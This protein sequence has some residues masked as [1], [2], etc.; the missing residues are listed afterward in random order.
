MNFK[1]GSTTEA[2]RGQFRGRQ[3]VWWSPRRLVTMIRHPHLERIGTNQS[4]FFAVWTGETERRGRDTSLRHTLALLMLSFL[5][6]APSVA[7]AQS[8]KKIRD[9]PATASAEKPKP[10]E[11][12][13][14]PEQRQHN[15]DSFDYVWTTIRDKYFDPSLGGLDWE[16]VKDELRPKVEK[17]ESMSQ[18][19]AVLLDVTSRLKVSHFAIIP[20]QAYGDLRQ[21]EKPRGGVTGIDV[22]VIDSRVLVTSVRKG[23]PAE[24]AGVKTGWEIVRIDEDDLTTKLKSLTDK[25]EQHPH[26]RTIL[27]GAVQSR[28]GGRIGE[29]RPLVFRDGDDREVKLELPFIEPKGR[30]TRFGHIPEFRVWIDVTSVDRNI[31]Y[32]GFNAF[33]DPIHVMTRFN[34]AMESFHDSEGIIIDVR[35]NGG[36]MGGMAMGMIGWLVDKG[37]PQLGTVIFRDNQLKM[38]VNPR[39]APFRGPV[40]VLIDEMSGSAAE[41]FASGVKD[42]GRAHLIGTRTAG[43]VLGSAIEKLPNGDGFQYAAVNYISKKTGKPLEGIGVTPDT[44]APH[45]REALL[46][47]RDLAMEAAI[48]WIRDQSRQ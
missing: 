31:G 8:S 47:G 33:I 11:R 30:K 39:P 44:P 48:K 20:S 5:L 32:I 28:L 29:T 1:A 41:F 36:G 43:A 34:E 26:R 10:A 21:A 38:L 17:A 22:R 4:G 12:A 35:G 7:S 2:S 14:T 23:S 25:L 19:R 24:E 6:I 40:V 37:Q 46:P 45:T 3:Y 16:K 42:I 18:V 27:V 15:L 13:L 9:L